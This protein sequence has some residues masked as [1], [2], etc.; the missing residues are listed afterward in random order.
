M[1]TLS[2]SV[3][4]PRKCRA[5]AAKAVGPLDKE[6]WLRTAEE[7]LKLAR[8]AKV[9]RLRSPHAS[10]KIGNFRGQ[11]ELP[12]CYSSTSWP[13]MPPNRLLQ[14]NGRCARPFKQKTAPVRAGFWIVCRK[15]V[16]KLRHGLQLILGDIVHRVIGIPTITGADCGGCGGGSCGT[17][18]GSRGA[19]WSGSRCRSIRRCGRC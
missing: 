14:Q 18:S 9:H 19:V 16:L 13:S 3:S 8:H 6:A 5:Q 2:G 1:T 11:L 4:K 7:W 15:L 10:G 17:G 12:P